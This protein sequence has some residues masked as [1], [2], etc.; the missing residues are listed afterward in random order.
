M[1][2]NLWTADFLS[3]HRAQFK[4]IGNTA[5][6]QTAVMNLKRGETSGNYGTDHPHADQ[7]LIVLS[8]EGS[9][10]INNEIQ[11]LHIGDILLIQAG[12][13]HQIRGES[14]ELFQTV[15]FYNP[16]AYPEEMEPVGIPSNRQPPRVL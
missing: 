11:P 13:K 1:G 10:K 5:H 15:S 9:A 3:S 12:E 7:I 4:V 16:I 14:D 2:M 8:G 6:T